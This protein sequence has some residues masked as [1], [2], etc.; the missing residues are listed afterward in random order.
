[1]TT[2]EASVKPTV[3]LGRLEFSGESVLCLLAEQIVQSLPKPQEGDKVAALISLQLVALR[4][5]LHSGALR[6]RVGTLYL[7]YQP[8]THFVRVSS[9]GERKSN[10]FMVFSLYAPEGESWQNRQGH[11]WDAAGTQGLTNDDP[12]LVDK[13]LENA[14][15]TAVKNLKAPEGRDAWVDDQIEM[16]AYLPFPPAQLVSPVKVPINGDPNHFHTTFAPLA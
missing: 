15:Q 6:P 5:G 4:I 12:A 9:G 16:G 10:S 3:R 1:M 7:A 2:I 13:L 14:M 8:M 11:E